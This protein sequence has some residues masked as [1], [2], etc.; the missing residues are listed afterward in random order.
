M[1]NVFQYKTSLPENNKESYGE[2]D[3][4]DFV[5]DF[6][7]EKLRGYSVRIEGDLEIE[8]I[9]GTPKID[10]QVGAHSFFSDIITTSNMSGGIEHINEYARF[11][12]MNCSAKNERNDMIDSKF[13]CELRT[14]DT[15]ISSDL[16]KGIKCGLIHKN[17]IDFSIKPL[18]CLNNVEGASKDVSYKK[19]GSVRISVRLERKENV[20]FGSDYDVSLMNY[21]LK[22][23]KLT[24]VT[25]PE[26]G[27]N[28]LQVMKTK[29]NFISKV[30]SS[31]VNIS[32]KV[33]SICTGVSS[34]FLKS[35]KIGSSTENT[36]A[37]EQLPNVKRLE[38][39]FNDTINNS[40]I[41]FDINNNV[42]LTSYYLHSLTNKN[43]NDSSLQ[44]L[45]S[46]DAYGIGVNFGRPYNLSNTRFSTQIES[47][48][49]NT[50]SYE[51]YLYFHCLVNL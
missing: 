27:D 22:N 49:K 11:V 41:T 38:F 42:D 3:N 32:S 31:F 6:P 26:D 40:F 13:L 46:N 33:P 34:S 51:M 39:L 28:S 50:E 4:V 37:L 2:F 17:D 24:Y 1:N 48:V 7:N 44:R 20:L 45:S 30:D 12:K 47:D 21:K 5:L 35:N 18:F 19:T 29:V 25:V 8:N 16:I 14:P 43:C 23:L 15:N 10:N 9:T 36:L